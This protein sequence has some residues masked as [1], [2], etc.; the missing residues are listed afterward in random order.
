MAIGLQRRLGVVR[1]VVEGVDVAAGRLQVLAHA[2][3]QGVHGV[4][5]VVA[6]PDTRLVGH[7]DH[8][9][10]RPVERRHGLLGARDPAKVLPARDI[11]AVLVQHPVAVEE[12]RGAQGAG[13]GGVGHGPRLKGSTVTRRFQIAPSGR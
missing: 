4:L 12:E 8:Q 11:A 5:G 7:H 3:V 1:R 9:P 10:A 2:G 13:V 6:A